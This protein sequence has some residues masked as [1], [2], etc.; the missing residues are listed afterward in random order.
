M[1]KSNSNSSSEQERSSNSQLTVLKNN[2]DNG[3]I[4]Y[5]YHMSDIHIRLDQRHREYEEV[6]ERVY[7]YIKND[8]NGKEQESIIVLTGD[9]L[10]SKTELRP[11]AISITS[12]FFK[13]LSE[14]ATVILIPGNHDC[15]VTN[16]KRLDAL[17]PIVE[18]V[19][20]LTDFYYLKTTGIYQ[21][22]NILF[23]VSSIIP[24]KNFFVSSSM[25]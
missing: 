11:E 19:N 8:I 24:G 23:G 22:Q 12:N 6:F 7:N 4:K 5:I 13:Q 20:N 25:K 21:Y 16:R 18:D 14:I 3:E 17:S 9:I 1:S 2:S 10:H 15:N